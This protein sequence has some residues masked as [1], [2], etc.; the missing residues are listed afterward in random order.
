MELNANLPPDIYTV[1]DLGLEPAD[2][3]PTVIGCDA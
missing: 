3:G 1:I 2:L